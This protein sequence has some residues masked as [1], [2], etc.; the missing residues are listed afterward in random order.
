[1]PRISGIFRPGF[2]YG[3]EFPVIC[4][5]QG[6]ISASSGRCIMPELLRVAFFPRIGYADRCQGTSEVFRFSACIAKES[7]VRAVRAARI[8]VGRRVLASLK[9]H[10]RD[11]SVAKTLH[12]CRENA[13]VGAPEAPLSGLKPHE[14]NPSEPQRNP[15]AHPTS[16]KR[17]RTNPSTSGQEVRPACSSH[18]GRNEPEGT[19]LGAHRGETERTRAPRGILGARPRQA[20]RNEPEQPRKQTVRA[21]ARGCQTNP[22]AP[23][24]ARNEPGPL[25]P[26]PGAHRQNGVVIRRSSG[27][28]RKPSIPIGMV[29]QRRVRL[30]ERNRGSQKLKMVP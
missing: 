17:Q 4:G 21:P 19:V 1:M 3:H 24:G 2:R 22:S 20:M 18:D 6:R 12:P 23:P 13:T 9:R 29:A 8:G 14:T 16:P 26:G 27:R 11:A 10:R 25:W 28:S 30:R 7:P 15:D 5:D